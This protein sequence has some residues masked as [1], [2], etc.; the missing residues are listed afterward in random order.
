MTELSGPNDN[1]DFDDNSF[2]VENNENEY[3][4]NSGFEMIKF[5]RE[6]KFIDFMSN[7][8]NNMI[9]YPTTVR[10]KNQYFLPDYYK[11][12]ENRKSENEYFK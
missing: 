3:F 1:P 6:D 5:A 4:F 10:E 2:L 9:P 8:G 12:I 11:Y 7:M